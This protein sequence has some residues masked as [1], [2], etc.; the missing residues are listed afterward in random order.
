MLE[1]ESVFR[2]KA[3]ESL[4]GAE[5]EFAN[6]RFNNCANRCYYACFQAAIAALQHAGVGPPG[7]TGHWS[8]SYV[9]AQFDGQLVYRRKLYP[10][11]LRGTLSRAFALR[12]ATAYL[13][14]RLSH[15]QAERLLR[16]TRRFVLAILVDE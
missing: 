1:Q 4:A 13:Q 10:S 16:R 9:A 5:S 8:H 11:D 14:D 12:Q 7:H 3:R 15:T 6:A 2:I